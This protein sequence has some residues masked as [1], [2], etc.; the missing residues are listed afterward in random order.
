MARLRRSRD[1]P[2]EVDLDLEGLGWHS[3]VRTGFLK[4][5]CDCRAAVGTQRCAA[6][7]ASASRACPWGARQG[8]AV[9]SER[10]ETSACG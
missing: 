6:T 7:P 10:R 5:C 3:R 4:K 8:R 1:C 2:E 9:A